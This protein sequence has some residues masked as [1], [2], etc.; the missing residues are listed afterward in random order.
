[1][2]AGMMV[3]VD[4]ALD[5]DRTVLSEWREFRCCRGTGTMWLGLLPCFR[6]N[7]HGYF[8]VLLQQLTNVNRFGTGAR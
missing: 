2:N 7:G 5:P 4:T 8:I 6:C 1:M 3:G